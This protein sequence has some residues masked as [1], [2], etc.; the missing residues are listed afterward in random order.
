M[1][2]RPY[3]INIKMNNLTQVWEEKKYMLV[4]MYR[5]EEIKKKKK[6]LLPKHNKNNSRPGQVYKTRSHYAGF[7][8]ALHRVIAAILQ[9]EFHM[10]LYMEYPDP[11]KLTQALI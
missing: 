1:N 3:Y 7:I 9:K 8:P 5:Q 4:G 6:T 11:S 2:I 10:K